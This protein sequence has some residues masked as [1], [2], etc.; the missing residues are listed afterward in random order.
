M[1]HTTTP[2]SSFY[3]SYVHD[4][5]QKII[6]NASLEFQCLWREYA[7]ARGAKPRSVLSDE[8]SSKLN[9]LQAELEASDLFEDE[10]SRRGVMRRAVPKT[11]VD[12]VGLDALLARLPETY[13]RALFSSWVAS[14]FVS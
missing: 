6:E 10:P 3:K 14:H 13:Q 5:Q 12:E 4:I 2:P 7:R 11:L 1:V 8:L 9:D